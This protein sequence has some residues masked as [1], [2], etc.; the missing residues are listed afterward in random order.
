[1]PVIKGTGVGVR[2]FFWFVRLVG[3][4]VLLIIGLNQLTRCTPPCMSTML[5]SVV[6]D[7]HEIIVFLSLLRGTR[8]SVN[9]ATNVQHS[10]SV[11]S[12]QRSNPLEWNRLNTDVTYTF[13]YQQDRETP[14]RKVIRRHRR[15]QP[16][17]LVHQPEQHS[18]V[19]HAD[20]LP[21]NRRPIMYT[22]YT[23]IENKKETGMSKDAN[24]RLIDAWQEEWNRHGCDTHVLGVE[25]AKRH[26]DFQRY[27]SM[28]DTLEIT[29]YERYCFLRYL[30]MAVVS[31]GWMC[32]YDT[33]P[34]HPHDGVIPNDGKFTVH[35]YSKNGGVPSLV[36]GSKEEFNR[37]AK[38]LIENAIQNKE[39]SHWSDMF[40]L[41]DVYMASGGTLYIRSDP[42]NVVPGQ[43]ITK[44]TR[45]DRICK[46]T[47]GKYAIHFSHYA[48]E[49]GGL[50]GAGPEHR[51]VIAQS[52]LA[53]WRSI[54]IDGKAD[55]G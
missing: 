22:F 3:C 42:T 39:K 20:G 10:M 38:V 24:Q 53:K 33:F 49:F 46:R 25:T 45:T 55:V 43:V 13:R 50:P 26:S 7:G 34:L 28:L 23:F 48:M 36:S 44:Q 21:G 1:L 35:E 4:P 15:L 29:I 31:G 54:C 6:R 52:F 41:H 12:G 18:L 14:E 47:N 32:D 17:A 9:V 8:R 11:T 51:A 40:A 5:E 30:A 37:M 27:N 2:N 16:S 19:V